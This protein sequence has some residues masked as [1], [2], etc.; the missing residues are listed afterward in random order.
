MAFTVPQAGPILK[1]A[2]AFSISRCY[3]CSIAADPEDGMEP[4]P[5][6]LVERTRQEVA[7]Y[8]QDQAASEMRKIGEAQPELLSFMVEFTRDLPLQSIDMGIYLFFVV[9]RIF[10]KGYAGDIGQVSDDE[11][12][13]C[14]EAN[15]DLMESLESAHYRF[16]ERAAEVQLASQPY[17]IRYVIDSFFEVS[18]DD[19]T[20]PV[21]DEDI[22]YLFLLLKTVID[23]LNG[24]TGG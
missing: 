4:I 20:D 23:V 12:I 7:A 14:Y 2:M 15:A 6:H 13:A 16:L 3:G 8:S 22:G 24:K 10:E 21:S 19:E 18:D 11:I 9:Y 17:V 5:E 1:Q